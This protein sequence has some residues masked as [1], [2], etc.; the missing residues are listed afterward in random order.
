MFLK[1]QNFN[2]CFLR[3]TVKI[4]IFMF[5]NLDF[6]VKALTIVG[7]LFVSALMSLFIFRQKIVAI[8]RPKEIMITPCDPLS[9]HELLHICFSQI[10]LT[11]QEHLF[12][13]TSLNSCFRLLQQRGFARE[14]ICIFLRKTLLPGVF[15]CE[16]TTIQAISRGALIPGGST[17]LLVNKYWGSSYFQVNNY[18]AVLFTR[19]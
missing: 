12:K 17:Y 14:Y 1:F 9:K 11:F 5:R 4:Q 3:P 6:L 13:E 2:V 16:N 7:V 10:L 15:E 19:E 8:F 18:W